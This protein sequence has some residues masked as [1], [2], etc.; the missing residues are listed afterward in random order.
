MKCLKA[1]CQNPPDYSSNYCVKHQPHCDVRSPP[2]CRGLV[3]WLFG[4]KFVERISTENRT[5][6]HNTRMGN[7]FGSVEIKGAIPP[8]DEKIVTYHGDICLRCGLV[9]QAGDVSCLK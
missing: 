7:T 2:S 6:G 1:G 5:Y 9:I 8:A 3:G 4:H